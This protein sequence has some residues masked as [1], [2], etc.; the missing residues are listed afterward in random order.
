[1]RYLRNA[2]IH[3]IVEIT[4]TIIKLIKGHGMQSFD[5]ITYKQFIKQKGE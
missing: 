3:Y 5:I 2:T 1:M 4:I